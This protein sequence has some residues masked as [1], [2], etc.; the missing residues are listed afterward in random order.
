MFRTGLHYKKTV[1]SDKE[2]APRNRTFSSTT[3]LE[4]YVVPE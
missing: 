3:Q 2:S 4:M 1:F